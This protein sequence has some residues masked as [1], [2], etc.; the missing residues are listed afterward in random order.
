MSSTVKLHGDAVTMSVAAML[1]GAVDRVGQRVHGIGRQISL[2][3][4]E[5]VSE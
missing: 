1:A 5:C 4:R 2:K 3:D